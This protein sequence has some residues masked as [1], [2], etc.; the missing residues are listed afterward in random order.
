MNKN[1]IP[2]K[3]DIYLFFEIIRQAVPKRVLD[4][5]LFLQRI[6]M[7]SRQ[8]MNYEIPTDV[9]LTGWNL[10]N[11]TILPV[12]KTI[13]DHILPH[14]CKLNDIYD[15]I[16]LFHTNESIAHSDKITIWEQLSSHGKHIITDATDSEFLSYMTQKYPCKS[17]TLDQQAYILITTNISS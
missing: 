3:N 4:V 11:H 9:D 16:F 17:I 12:F 2:N 10:S 14:D 5:D 1:F 8:A 7:I 15:L 13:Y 6:G